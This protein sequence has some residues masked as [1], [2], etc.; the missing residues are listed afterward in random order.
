MENIKVSIIV[1]IYNV[2]KYLAGSLDS[3]LAQTLSP[4]EI[5]C[6]NDGSTDSSPKI[7]ERYAALDTRIKVIHQPNGGLSAAR[8]TGMDA[9]Q[10]E[11]LYFLDSDDQ[12][13]APDV[14]EKLYTRAHADKL[15]MLF[16]EACVS[17]EGDELC[18]IASEPPDFYHRR[19]DYPDI[20]TGQALYALMDARSEYRPSA[21]LYLLHREFVNSSKLRFPFGLCH[22]DEVFTLEALSFAQRTA[23]VPLCGYNRLW[24]AGSIMTDSNYAF[25]IYGNFFVCKLLQDFAA[26]QLIDVN[27][28]FLHL[29]LRHARD[30]GR[31]GMLQY[32]KLSISKRKAFLDSLTPADRITIRD[33]LRAN[34]RWWFK[35]QVRKTFKR[36]LPDKLLRLRK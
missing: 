32:M 4:I 17:Y 21:W 9:A 24:R 7:L 8:N 18:G 2:E 23:C 5:L 13:A 34:S 35:R 33:Q 12:I 22:E 25:R 1:P 30:I 27:A 15:D 20:L 31:R 11:Y 14:L 6:V 36:L 26:T 10:G 16:F 29:Y 3:A 28:E 19:H